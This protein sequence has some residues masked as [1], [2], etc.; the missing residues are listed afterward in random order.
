MKQPLLNDHTAGIVGPAPSAWL[1]WL[2]EN[3]DFPAMPN[4]NIDVTVEKVAD[5]CKQVG[6][7]SIIVEP[8]R[9]IFVWD[10]ELRGD[11]NP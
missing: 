6:Y 7:K 1:H 8:T 5:L 9:T 2:K 3:K 4:F 11:G 10:S